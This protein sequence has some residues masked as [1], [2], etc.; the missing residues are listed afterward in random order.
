MN[1]PKNPNLTEVETLAVIQA[2][3]CEI[4][5]RRDANRDTEGRRIDTEAD[6]I[7]SI[8]PALTRARNKLG[9]SL[10]GLPG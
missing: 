3:D 4:P 5:A 9:A 2:L 8:I 10:R 1:K 6:A 7:D